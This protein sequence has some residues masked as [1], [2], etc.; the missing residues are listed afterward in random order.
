MQKFIFYWIIIQ[1]TANLLNYSWDSHLKSHAINAIKIIILLIKNNAT[2]IKCF[3][4]INKSNYSII[5]E[6]NTEMSELKQ[7]NNELI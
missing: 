1:R 3:E 2:K 6:L 4:S 5:K 7:I